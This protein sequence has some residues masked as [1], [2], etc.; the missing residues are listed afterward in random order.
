MT[1]I[2]NPVLRGFHPDPCLCQ[3]HGKYYLATSTFQWVPAVS[4]YE[5]D[6]LI[7]WRPL[8]GAL[9]DL[10]LRG[11][12]DSAGV[13]APDLTYDEA[14]ERF[15]LTYTI[16][17]Q[18]DGIFKDVRNYV[19][20]AEDPRGPW[21]EP[22]FVNASGFDPGFFHE[23]GRHYVINPQWDPRPAEGHHKFNGLVMQEFSLEDGPVGEARVVLDNSD[24]VNWLREGPHV[25]KHDGWYYIACAEGGTG[26]RHRIRMARSR[27]LWGPYEMCP[28]PLVCAWCTESAL[29]KSGH[30]NFAQA[31]DGSWYVTFLCSRYLPE[32]DG[33][34]HV[35]DE[36]EAGCSPLGRET[37]MAQI[38]WRDGWLRLADG[39]VA[40]PATFDVAGDAPVP[41]TRLAY[42]TDFAA[43]ADLWK[44]GWLCSRRLAGDWW[45]TGAE[46][47][48]L[49]GGDSPS[50]SF[51]RSEIV[52]RACSHAWH[53]ECSLRFDPRHYNQSAGLI[54]EYDSRT[55]HYL[56]LGWDEKRACR[57]I[58][59][60]S[61]DKGSFTMP[62]GDAGIEVLTSVATVR[63]GVS[64][65][66]YDLVFSYAF[67]DA[68][69]QTVEHGDGNPLVLDASIMSDEHV[70]FGAY[71]GTVVGLTCIDMWDKSAVATFGS[72]TYCDR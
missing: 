28:E 40:A 35:F 66:G 26:R 25:L 51:E 50:S 54:C 42:E 20:T 1:T 44:E 17:Y 2:A 71:T 11:V 13:W 69:W 27:E 39:G 61:C 68:E 18:I 38:V 64:V 67:D 60:L 9:P 24:A 32:R 63:L 58:Q 31:P 56:Y 46:G 34:V 59:V 45:G 70:G 4:L 10:D 52:R 41:S 12:P 3:A 43:D 8:G 53:A 15:W 55:F 23:D 6:D 62:L 14:S 65:D 30:G 37:G 22:V 21:S 72:F 33:S 57:T 5:S 29:R 47:L 7:E 49:K 48:T 36:H 16:A 19:V